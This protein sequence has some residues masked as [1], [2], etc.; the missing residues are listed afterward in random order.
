MKYPSTI[1]P[2]VAPSPSGHGGICNHNAASVAS[3]LDEFDVG[4]EF[5]QK[6][7][8]I[9][10]IIT[11]LCNMGCKY[12]FYDKMNRKIS[13]ENALATVDWLLS[14][15]VSGNMDVSITFF[16]GEP[17]LFEDLIMRIVRYG[18]AR[19]K[20]IVVPRQVRGAD[21]KFVMQQAAKRI[22]FGGVSNC[23]NISDGFIDFCVK[24]DVGWLASYDGPYAQNVNRRED[25]AKRVVENINRLRKAGIKVM[26][27]Q[28]L[29]PGVTDHIFD[30]LMGIFEE[31]GVTHVFQNPVHHGIRPYDEEDFRNLDRAFT[32]EAAM[33]IEKRLAGV[34][35]NVWGISNLEKHVSGVV[36]AMNDPNT[37]K[38]LLEK[39]VDRT[40][41]ACKGSL[42][43]TSQGAIVPC[44]QMTVGYDEWTLGHVKSREFDHEMRRAFREEQFPECKGCVVTQCASCRTQN[45]YATGSQ[46]CIPEDVCRYQRLLWL[47]A[48]GVANQLVDKTPFYTTT[49]RK[50]PPPSKPQGA[51]RGMPSRA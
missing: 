48:V 50:V 23:W 19:A 42:A 7:M 24:H 39:T 37:I 20:Q 22:K 30:D 45:H 33:T 21:G 35:P 8:A 5:E 47:H 17:T 43:V 31:T 51:P 18:E 25:S 40:C 4:Y 32:A 49:T 38:G 29:S 2:A 46:S 16:G 9:H 28:Q 34:G 15:Q 10:L 36:R 27:A 12:C 6:I 26:V 44:Q 3:I 13:L 11:D 14:P 41:G 1:G